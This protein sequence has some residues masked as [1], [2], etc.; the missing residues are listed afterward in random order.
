ML[1]LIPNFGNAL[2][3][4]GA[5]LIAFGVVAAVH[6]YGHYL[7]GRLCGI[8]AEV[9]SL[10]FGPELW[11]YEDQ[12]GTRWRI[13]AIPLGGYV[14]FEGDGDVSSTTV[15]EESGRKALPSLRYTLDSA[16]LWAR[17]ATVAAGPVFNFALSILVFA[18]VNMSIGVAADPLTVDELRPMPGP[19]AE[20]RPGDEIVAIDGQEVPDFN[21]LGA[22]IARLP[23]LPLLDYTVRRDGRFE[24]VNAPH[25]LPSFIA[26]VAPG[27]AAAD[28]GVV[29]GDVVLSVDGEEVRT[30]V[31]LRDAVA[32][33]DDGSL[34]LK[35]WRDGET[36][37]VALTPRRTDLPLADGTFETRY[38]IGVTGGL[39]FEPRTESPGLDRALEF[40]VLETLEMI[41]VSLSGVYHIAAGLISSC[42]LRGP[43]GIAET[44]GAAAS[45][46]WVSF[47]HFIAVLSAAIGFINLFPIPVLDGGHLVFHV[48]EAVTGRQPGE[49][50]RSI[51]TGIGLALIL[52]LMS[53]ALLNDI[54]CP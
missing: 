31:E 33:S 52:A 15:A 1:D 11:S 47:I 21:E 3:T 12:R 49:R 34:L 53:F 4:I 46:G 50:V 9:F 39:L 48:W 40:G 41:R 35:L 37:E 36:L 8:K 29:E 38:L 44:S 42:N 43:I 45:Q 10:G 32:I 26:G 16:P 14:R 25:P 7:V 19:V 13:A 54:R 28:A 24:I 5:F 20:L 18:A 2:Y 22:F 23:T 6:E 30:F 51:L 27:S 17:A